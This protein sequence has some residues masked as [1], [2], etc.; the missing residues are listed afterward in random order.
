MKGGNRKMYIGLL[1]LIVIVGYLM[2]QRPKDETYEEI[3][4]NPDDLLKGFASEVIPDAV[5]NVPPP[6]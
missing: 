2:T 3:E 5:K 1:V 4:K 6:A